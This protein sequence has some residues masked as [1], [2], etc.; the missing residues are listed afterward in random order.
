MLFKVHVLQPVSN[1]LLINDSGISSVLYY[2][3]KLNSD[4]KC[5]IVLIPSCFLLIGISAKKK[6]R[7]IFLYFLVSQDALDVLSALEYLQ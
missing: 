3:F 2:K 4:S 5:E 7:L 6:C 1:P